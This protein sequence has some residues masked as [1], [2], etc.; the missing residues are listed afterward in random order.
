MDIGLQLI[1]VIALTQREVVTVAAS[2]SAP[3]PQQEESAAADAAKI[4][5]MRAI[6]IAAKDPVWGSFRIR[7]RTSISGC[8]GITASATSMNPS[9]WMN[10]VMTK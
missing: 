2:T 1:T 8:R 9:R 10:P 4:S 6:L 3:T 7:R 5:S